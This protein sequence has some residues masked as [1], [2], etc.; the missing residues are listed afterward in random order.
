MPT[1][2]DADALAE[3]RHGRTGKMY[4]DQPYIFH[5]R[6][7]AAEIATRYA[8]TA[9]YDDAVIAALLHDTV[10]DTDVTLVELR[11]LGYSDRVIRALDACTRRRGETYAMFIRRCCRDRLGRRIKIADNICNRRRLDGIQDTGRREGLR[12]RYAKAIVTLEQA[13]REDVAA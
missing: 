10:E 2:E 6:E 1:V 13:E 3:E 9:E 7:V 12:R 4:G 5:P 8:G 11:A